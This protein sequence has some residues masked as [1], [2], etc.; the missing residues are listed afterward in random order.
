MFRKSIIRSQNTSNYRKNEFY[1]NFVGRGYRVESFD[2]YF[3]KKNP[4]NP[5][6]IYLLKGNN[7]NTRVRCEICSKLTIKTP[8][9]RHWC[10]F[11]VFIVNF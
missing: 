10:R 4:N 11:G 8:E 1:K 3:P 2:C 7:R 5:V 9:R 6:D